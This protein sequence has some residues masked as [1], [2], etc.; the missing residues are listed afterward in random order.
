MGHRTS[1]APGTFSWVDLGTT[2]AGAAKG[3]YGA[4]FGWEARDTPA[5][6]DRSYTMLFRDGDLVAGLYEMDEH[7]RGAGMVP[8]WLSYVTVESV[9]DAARRAAELGGTVVRAPMDIQDSG[10][11]AV[12]ADPTGAVLGLWEPRAHIGAQRVNDVGALCWNDVV[13]PDPAAAASFYTDL[14][15]WEITELDQAG[16]YRH[17]RNR[18]ASNGGL[19]PSAMAGNPPPHVLPYFNAGSIDD[20]ARVIHDRGGRLVT[21]PMQVPAGRF[22]VAQDP[23]GAAFALFEGDVDD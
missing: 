12:V 22:A 8:N 15:G 23:Q 4:V 2:E 10:R 11:M 7:Q 19:M 13:T 3:F 9:D 16:G 18:G 14:L 5:G 17:I 20:T 21:Q 1:Y 6:E